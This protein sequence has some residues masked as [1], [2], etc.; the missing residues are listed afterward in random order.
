MTGSCVKLYYSELKQ[1]IGELGDAPARARRRSRATT[2]P[3]CRRGSVL[4]YGA[5]V[6]LAD[7]RG[8]LV[9][10]PAQHHLRA[11]P[12]AARASR[13]ERGRRGLPAQR[14]PARAPGGHPPLLR[15]ARLASR[16]CASSRRSSTARSGAS[17]PRWACSRCG[18]PRRRAA[19]GSAAPTPCSCSRSSDAGWC[20]ARWSGAICWR[21]AVDGA[22]RGESVVGGVD[23]LDPRGGP[24]LV[25]HFDA[26]DAL[27]VLR[28]DGVYRARPALAARASRSPRRSIRTRRSAHAARAAAGRADRRR[29]AARAAAARGRRARRRRSCSASP[30]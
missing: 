11:H 21:T 19:S 30:R 20:R 14:R 24:L 9:A 10:D 13:A 3:G 4:Y 2:S 23:A 8:G 18:C 7:D 15:R 6:A 28:A 22:A 5:P 27:V 29:R 26:L 25:E 1:R 16:R 17:S 12:A